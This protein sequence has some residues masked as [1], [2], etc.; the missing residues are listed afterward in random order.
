V[1]L[2]FTRRRLGSLLIL[3]GVLAV[4]AGAFLPLSSLPGD[5][6]DQSPALPVIPGTT[7]LGLPVGPGTAVALPTAGSATAFDLVR[8][9]VD[10]PLLTSGIGSVV[11]DGALR[12][13]ALLIAVALIAAIASNAIPMLKGFAGI[14]AGIGLMGSAIV[15]GVV[16]GEHMRTLNLCAGSICTVDLHAG[17]WVIAIGF[18]SI[19]AGG[20]LGA[21]RPFAGMLSGMSLAL[22]GFGVGAGLAYLVASQH[23]LDVITHA[24]LSMPAVITG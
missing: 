18:F 7:A 4:I 13:G 6:I 1:V 3:G 16:L 20:A 9:A 5:G 14:A 24:T 10:H 17:L 22:G 12:A 15:A 21:M 11:I 23:V 2:I 19:L 8:H